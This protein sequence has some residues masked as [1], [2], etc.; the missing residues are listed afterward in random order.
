MRFCGLARNGFASHS[1]NG[2]LTARCQAVGTRKPLKEKPLR[3]ITLNFHFGRIT[4]TRRENTFRIAPS[5]PLPC[6][7]AF[8]SAHPGFQIA[9]IAS[10]GVVQVNRASSPSACD[11]MPTEKQIGANNHTLTADRLF[12]F[13][14]TV[15]PL[16]SVNSGFNGE[17][18]ATRSSDKTPPCGALSIA[19]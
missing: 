6:V 4:F 1:I 17:R 14:P 7:E 2:A 12:L 8:S 3:A 18:V 19:F 9:S 10:L 5:A 15:Q 16:S 11:H 13:R